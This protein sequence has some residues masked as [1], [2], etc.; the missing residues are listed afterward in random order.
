[1]QKKKNM[2]L[3]KKKLKVYVYLYYKIYQVVL[4]V[5]RGGSCYTAVMFNRSIIRTG[6]TGRGAWLWRPCHGGCA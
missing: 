1:M 2:K 6:P 4:V 3:N 5:C